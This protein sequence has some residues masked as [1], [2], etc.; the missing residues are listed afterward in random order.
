MRDF[1]KF[2]RQ[3]KDRAHQAAVEA[4]R[5]ENLL[6]G[7]ERILEK[8]GASRAILFGSVVQ[9]FCRN[10]SDI[11][12]YVEGVEPQRYWDLWRELEQH[13][14]ERVDLYCD[15]DNPVFVRKIKERGRVLYEA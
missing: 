4:T 15:R 12:I 5:R 3:R 1:T 7:I 8:Y 2:I 10:D 6:K 14:E 11:D 9:G 13:T